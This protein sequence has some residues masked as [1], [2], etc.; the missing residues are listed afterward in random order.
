MLGG[1]SHNM[2]L[3]GW[4][5]LNEYERCAINITSAFCRSLRNELAVIQFIPISH[6]GKDTL[7]KNCFNKLSR[8]HIV[9]SWICTVLHSIIYALRFND[10]LIGQLLSFLRV[11][12]KFV[13]KVYNF[14]CLSPMGEMELP[15]DY[16][17]FL[18]IT[19]INFPSF[20]FLKFNFPIIFS[21]LV[22]LLSCL[23]RARVS[24]PFCFKRRFT[25]SVMTLCYM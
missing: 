18:K 17:G 24:H 23:D 13:S 7:G 25:H 19:A 11:C 20:T 5:N 16:E 14:H 4:E 10:G 22:F 9:P 6:R 12:E 1:L 3:S 21:T 15:L 8:A 2:A